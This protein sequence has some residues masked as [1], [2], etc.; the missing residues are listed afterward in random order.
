MADRSV[1][2]LED[3][4]NSASTARV[5][6]LWGIAHRKADDPERIARPLFRN[7]T[8]NTSIIVKHRIHRNE[9]DHFQTRRRTATKILIPI[10]Q[11]NLR[12]GARYV[13]IGQRG[14]EE[15]LF[16]AFG[17]LLDDGDPDVR[18]LKVLDESPSLDPFLLRELLRRQDL[19]PAACYFEIS[20]ADAQRMFEFAQRE[21]EP[22]V[23]LS[24]GPGAVTGE[25]SAKMTS[26]ILGNGAGAELEPLRLTLQLEKHQYQE[27]IFC[28]KAFLYYKWQ[29]SRLLPRAGEVLREI[30]DKRTVGATSDDTQAYLAQARENIRK[31]LPQSCRRVKEVLGVYDAAYQGLT[32]NGQPAA[33][34][35]FLLRAPSM[36]NELGERLGGIEHITSFWRYRFPQASDAPVAPDEL[37]D[38]FMDFEGSLSAEEGAEGL[39]SRIPVQVLEIG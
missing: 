27:G 15:A 9:A 19:E 38:L 20:P 1:R 34:R 29:L 18:T 30:A 11:S 23:R 33:F 26:K 16:Q 24:T 39:A 8:L 6:N 4:Q 35:D 31:Q 28:W 32:A 25:R 14:F 3:L 12:V 37:A 21:I 17:L 2:S 5:L 13:F 10:E 22:L 36:F 7:P